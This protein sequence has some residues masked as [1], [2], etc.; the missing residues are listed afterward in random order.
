MTNK[1]LIRP[2][3]LR[4]TFTKDNL[5]FTFFLILKFVKKS[6]MTEKYPV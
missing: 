5:C 2:L 3:A 1:L 4:R 6:K